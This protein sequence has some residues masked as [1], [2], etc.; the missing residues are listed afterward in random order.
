[1]RAFYSAGGV[2]IWVASLLDTKEATIGS[3]ACVEWQ[4][5][6]WY[7]LCQDHKNRQQASLTVQ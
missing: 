2:E 6:E 4:N 7:G 3:I 1:M 5:F